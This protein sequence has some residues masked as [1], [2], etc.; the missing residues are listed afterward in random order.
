MKYLILHCSLNNIVA[1]S[2]NANSAVLVLLL[3]L[4]LVLLLLPISVT[5]TSI[6]SVTITASYSAAS[7]PRLGAG[8]TLHVT[9]I[10][11]NPS[12]YIKHTTQR[13]QT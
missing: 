12:N 10:T 5:F 13:Y 7:C 9:Q 8:R 4:F 2:A 3:M 1:I 11:L 6:S